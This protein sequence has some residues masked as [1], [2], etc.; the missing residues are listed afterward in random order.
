VSTPSISGDWKLP[1]IPGYGLAAIIAAAVL[2]PGILALIQVFPIT[3]DAWLALLMKE[4]GADTLTIEMAHRPVFAWILR[5]CFAS[6]ASYFGIA[7]AVNILCW[8]SMALQVHWL[9]A[10]LFPEWRHLGTLAAALAVAPILSLVQLSTLTVTL[11]IILPTVLSLAAL[12]MAVRSATSG[13][14]RPWLWAGAGGLAGL[15]ELLSEYAAAGILTALLFLLYLWK[16]AVARETKT[17]LL[18]AAVAICAGGAVGMVVFKLTSVKL[19]N[20]NSAD[21]STS[22]LN[23]LTEMPFLIVEAYWRMLAGAFAV[24]AARIRF[25]M[26]ERSYLAAAV[27][28]IL[29]AALLVWTC[30]KMGTSPGERRPLFTRL[31]LVFCMLAP[32][33]LPV[34][35][36]S[37]SLMTVGG[38]LEDYA[39]RL[40]LPAVPVAAVAF[41]VL[42]GLLV[43]RRYIPVA[44]AAA[45]FV[46]G[47][48]AFLQAWGAYQDWQKAVRLGPVLE[49]FVR[50]ATGLIVVVLS[51]YIGRDYAVTYKVSQDWPAAKGERLWVVGDEYLPYRFKRIVNRE[52]R[53]GEGSP[54]HV[55]V[56][57]VRR[58]GIVARMLYVEMK[59]R[60]ILVE[61]YCLAMPTPKQ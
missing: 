37:D 59:N 53:C 32:G 40:Y 61:P 21:I 25:P 23:H 31:L 18:R 52:D 12:M 58:D 46:I 47:N 57:G 60:Q 56:T 14:K 39:T 15:A 26:A 33:L 17:V 24:A 2:L 45:G 11:P 27:F 5:E 29:I 1:A 9:T 54:L 42:L 36:R 22:L 51:E 35:V 20:Y 49:P 19:A 50:D 55:E 8:L 10:T 4:K 41:V 13:A 34:I 16:E 3:D 38:R 48:S 7:L 28:G 43:R 30:R 6:R 44:V